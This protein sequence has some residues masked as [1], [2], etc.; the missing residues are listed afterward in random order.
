[1]MRT[2]IASVACFGAQDGLEHQQSLLLPAPLLSAK[3]TLRGSG[4]PAQRPQSSPLPRSATTTPHSAGL[5]AEASSLNLIE[6]QFAIR[7]RFTLA[8]TDD[9][10]HIAR[11]RRIYAY[12]RYRHRKLANLKHP[13]NA[14][15]FRS[16]KLEQH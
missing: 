3:A 14:Y 15:S 5:D 2:G 11:R 16:I 9:L 12:L 4:Q 10:T 6:A 1:M 7:K 13:P 8:N